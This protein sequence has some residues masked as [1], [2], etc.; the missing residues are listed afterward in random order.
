VKRVE[1]AMTHRVKLLGMIKHKNSV[2]VNTV[3]LVAWEL[4]VAMI[5]IASVASKTKP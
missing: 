1:K 3:Q 4:V 5:S 2:A